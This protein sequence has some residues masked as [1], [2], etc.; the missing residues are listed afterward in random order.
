MFE[1]FQVIVSLSLSGGLLILLLFLLRPLLR[2]RFSKRWQY[3][4]WLLVILRLLLPM[5]PPESP[6][7]N[8][9]I[10]M[11]ET[12]VSVIGYDPWNPLPYA[13]TNPEYDAE[14]ANPEPTELQDFAAAVWKSLWMGW[15]TVALSMLIRKVTAYQS[16][17]RYVRTGRETVDDPA[18]LDRVAEIGAEIG[19]KKPIEL[20]VNSLA[21]SPML[22]GI[23]NPCV[24]LPTA[25]LPEEDLR[26]VLLHELTHYRRRDVLYKWL[27]QITV[28]IHWFNPL[29]YWMAHETERLCELSCDE[30]VLKKLDPPARRAYG[31]ALLRTITTGG[32]YKPALPSATLGESG[33][34]LKER[35]DTIMKFKKPTRLAA[36]MSLLLIMILTV[37]A[38]AAGA[39]T[40][41]PAAGGEEELYDT[42]SGYWEDIPATRPRFTHEA[43]YHAPYMFTI[44]W[45]MLPQDTSVEVALPDGSK[46]E[47]W[48]SNSGVLT[49]LEHDP[50]AREALS[51]VIVQLW[52][53][54][55][56]TEYPLTSPMLWYYRDFSEVDTAGMAAECYKS[57]G[58]AMF[59]T[60][61][62][63]LGQTEQAVWL[64]KFY[65]DSDTS[66][67]SVAADSLP[68][69]GELLQTFAE[70]AY[71]SGN[72]S[73][74]SVL[75]NRMSEKTLKNWLDRA[76][77]DKSA[78]F[79]SML[80]QRLRESEELNKL[81]AELDRKQD[82]E[83]KAGGVTRDGGT[84]YCQGEQ[85]YIF[86][87]SQPDNAFY[88]MAM[89]PKAKD[90]KSVKIVR[91]AGGKITGATYLTE[92]EITDLFGDKDSKDWDDDEDRDWDW[93]WD[94]TALK[95][96]YKAV[97]V[98]VD[99]KNYYYQGKLVNIF[100]DRREDS[101]FYN[102]AMNPEGSVNIKI[103]R[104]A[105]NTITGVAPL[106]QA[107]IDRYFVGIHDEHVVDVDIDSVSNGEY[108]WLG[109]F[110][111]EE[112]DQ[113]YY[114]VSAEE[115]ERLTV[116]FA[117][118]R[119]RNPS[120]TYATVSNH[121][122][123]GDLEVVAGPLDSPEKEGT[124]HLFVH[125]R[126]GELKNV[127]GYVTIV[128]AD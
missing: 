41:I 23:R 87:D 39:Y 84:Y 96:A 113:I 21:A 74:F 65:T 44:G 69:D 123:D 46:M 6:A 11:D 125:T 93:D 105:D 56:D 10:A 51:A 62:A 119:A 45:N 35:L 55:K 128:E 127:T 92:A 2:D 111:L 101:S 40:G 29:V 94:D 4:I 43:Y 3:Y 71:T 12:A 97:G 33:K 80:L 19:V 16:F 59:K 47:V 17:V 107:E 24:V 36:V 116:G 38:A 120:T 54:T 90:G 104:D 58:L 14:F 31:D 60:A 82:E 99:G 112:G 81:E 72:F 1:I 9:V 28:C 114:D 122:E 18:L 67:F 49:W 110:E 83:Y 27:V 25:E 102:L 95:E 13:N 109:A 52:Q 124:Y 15:L 5:G 53:D 86:L 66:F 75:M 126:G 103:V 26:Y 30:A 64:E 50:D 121:R 42:W 34:L 115:G 79:Q 22:L 76:K 70:K 37:T 68:I 117:K 88:T 100:L 73:F 32:N 7:G 89:N 57:H 106:T 63:M 8:A 77:A 108:V 98:T 85:L 118:S 61:F 78:A 20:Y 48:I 91:D